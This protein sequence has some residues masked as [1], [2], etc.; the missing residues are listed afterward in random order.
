MYV[1]FDVPTQLWCVFN[2]DGKALSSHSSSKD[3]YQ[4]LMTYAINNED[5]K[6]IAK[7]AS[8]LQA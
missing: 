3:A 8:K 2:K 6:L 5:Y 1:Q 7:V 4:Q